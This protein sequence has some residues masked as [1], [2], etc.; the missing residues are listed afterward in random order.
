MLKRALASVIFAAIMV[1]VIADFRQEASTVDKKQEEDKKPIT[2]PEYVLYERDCMQEVITNSLGMELTLIP[3]GS[4]MMG[5]VPGDSEAD[6][7]E[8]PQHRVEI[9]K[10]FYMGVYE[11]TQAEWEVIMPIGGGGGNYWYGE[12]PR[13]PVYNVSWDDAVAFCMLLSAKEGVT[14][15]LPTEA[16]WEYA[17]RGGIEGKIYV[18]GD[19]KTPLVNGV[20]YANVSDEQNYKKYEYNKGYFDRYGYFEDYDDGYADTSPVGSYAPNSFGLYDMAGNVCE[21]CQDWYDDDYYSGSPSRDP[22]G[23]ASG[24]VGR[25]V[26]NGS[27][28]LEPGYLRTSDRGG[29]WQ[30][31]SNS[32]IGFRVVREVE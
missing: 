20:K 32:Y 16:E 29:V 2:E 25:V 4:F 31:D 12:G 10:A 26:R 18:W 21:W 9:T 17:A 28:N 30:N 22:V 11:V 15:R 7:D 6:D 5:A 14:Y 27:Y 8:K 1:L 23:P 24:S 13:Y 19:E 3:A